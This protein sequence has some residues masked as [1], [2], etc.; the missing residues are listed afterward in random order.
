MTEKELADE[1]RRLLNLEIK[2]Q[3][4]SSIAGRLKKPSSQILDMA[5][6][7]KSFGDGAARIMGPI[8]RP[9]LPRDWLIFADSH[10]QAIPIDRSNLVTP[11]FSE[12]IPPRVAEIRD[13]ALQ[14]DDYHLGLLAGEARGILKQYAATTKGSSRKRRQL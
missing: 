10:E 13:M 3:G 11:D 6:G 14:L 2:D 8:I 9:D 1:R 5:M 12:K 4:L 7:R